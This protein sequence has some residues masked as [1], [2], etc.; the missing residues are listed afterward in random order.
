MMTESFQHREYEIQIA[1][2]PPVFQAAIYPTGPNM[3]AVDWTAHPIEA[4]NRQTC[5][6]A[7]KMRIDDAL[8]S[9]TI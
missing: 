9:S 2:K 4:A 1:E 6:I 3:I 7:A 5:L 8:S